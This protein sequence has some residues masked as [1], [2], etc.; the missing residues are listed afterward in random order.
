MSTLLGYLFFCFIALQYHTVMSNSCLG[1]VDLD[2]LIFDKT[3]QRFPYTLVKFDIAFPYGDKHEAFAAFSKAAHA[4][5]D[6]ILIATV[7]IKDYGDHDNMKLGER[8]KVDDKN[9]PTILLFQK[10]D[11]NN[12]MQFPSYLDITEDNLKGFISS[13]TDIYIGREGCLKEFND[14]AKNFANLDEEEQQKRLKEAEELQ[15]KLTKDLDKQN[16]NIYKIYME[17][18]QSKG[19][20]FV[21]DETKRLARLKAGKV[22][23]VKKSELLIKLNILE[24]FRVNKLTKEEL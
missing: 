12:Y 18:V 2:E 7:G 3:I 13:H 17:K 19:Y 15:E 6:D 22:S 21:E 1:C 4:V 11:S 16:A 20:S 5:T 8:F 9:Y 24:A 14:L 23:E 10:G